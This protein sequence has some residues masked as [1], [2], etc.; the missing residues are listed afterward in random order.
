MGRC[1]VFPWLIFATSDSVKVVV[2]EIQG[3]GLLG[4]E[5]RAH[6]AS[7]VIRRRMRGF[8]GTFTVGRSWRGIING[9][10]YCC[11]RS[12]SLD[13]I[14]VVG[15]DFWHHHGHGKATT[16]IESGETGIDRRERDGAI[17]N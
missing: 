8:P 7:D 2:L 15:T 14:A 17:H 16:A 9:C 1:S 11:P 10:I 3:L 4:D 12:G 5:E 13:V 6:S